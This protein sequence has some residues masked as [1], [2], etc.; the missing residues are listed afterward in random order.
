MFRRILI[1][2]LV[3]INVV[4]FFLWVNLESS[5][6]NYSEVAQLSGSEDFIELKNYFTNLAKEKGA[7]YAYEILKRVEVKP[8][9]DMHL[10]GHIVGEIL[11]QQKGAAG[12]RY[13]TQDFRNACSHTIVVGLFSEKGIES[14]PDIVASCKNAPG[15]KGA[16]NM[17][18]H[19]LGHGVLAYEGYR[20]DKA[21][22]VCA[23]INKSGKNTAEFPECVGGTIMEIISG[24]DHDRELW[25]PKNKEY[26]GKPDPLYPCNADIIPHEAKRMCYSYLTPHLF[27]AAG[28]SLA[29]PTEEHFKKAFT[30]CESIK[31]DDP[32]RLVCFAG[33]GKEFVVLAKSRDIRNINLLTGTE[34]SK[35]EKWCNLASA[36]DGIIA[37]EMSALDSMYWGGENDVKP[38][39]SFCNLLKN[40]SQNDACFLHLIGVVNYFSTNNES[41]LSFCEKIPSTFQKTC[42]EKVRS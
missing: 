28:A 8:G 6:K 12:M 21:V 39:I 29:S 7:P 4:L 13:C 19:G 23:K 2:L 14:L 26:M 20:L 22:E 5:K 30:F 18:F 32:N 16:Y 1:F 35:I 40:S 42:Q 37:C 3:L 15:G 25:G 31:S 27:V 24:G 17:C 34:L 10:L 33:F 38:A 41:F 9:T 11:Y 36:D